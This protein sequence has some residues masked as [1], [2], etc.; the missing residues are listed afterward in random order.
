MK[1]IKKAEISKLDAADKITLIYLLQEQNNLL[2][3]K[4]NRLETKVKILEAMLAKN[5]NNSSKPPSSDT[6]KPKKRPQKTSSSRKKSG[7]KPGGQ[8][9]HKDHTLEMSAHPDEVI[10]LKVDS[11]VNCHHHLKNVAFEI[12]RRQQFEIPEPKIWITEYQAQ[13]KHCKKCGCTTAAC[14]PENITHVTQYGPRAKG[15][16]VYMNQYQLLPFDRASDF[17]KT[18]Y[19]HKVSPGTIVNAVSTLSNRFETVDGQIKDLLIKAGLAHGDETG[20]NINGDKQWLHTVGTTQLT[21]YAIHKKRG[22]HAT[23][24]IGILPNFE[25]T[26]IHDHWKSYFTYENIRHGLCNAHH[27]RELRFIHEHH[28]IKWAKKISNL[29]I[30][31]NEHKEKLLN[32]SKQFSKRQI[33][34]YQ[35][36]YDD[37]LSNAVKEQAR[38][39]TV[40]SSNLLKRL[41]NYKA[42]VLLFMTDIEVPF[43]NNLSEQD[44]RMMKVKQKISGCFRNKAGGNNFCRIRS[45]ISTAMKNKKN[46]FNILQESFQTI[47]SVDSLLANS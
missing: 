23:E 7:R 21:H 6:H 36:A 27:I 10:N 1:K 30:G 25:G 44:I 39:G 32:M 42:E 24:D 8:P 17:F 35:D 16:M 37:I 46:I 19:G 47:I 26:L 22:R 15:L 28:Y 34:N 31:V 12:K 5:S 9:G 3:E 11:C 38:R 18:V 40:D 13:V 29:L 33:K 4:Y 20:V 45:V 43:T 14:F 41:K 2:L